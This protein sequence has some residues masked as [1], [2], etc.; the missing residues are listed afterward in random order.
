[1]AEVQVQKDLVYRANGRTWHKLDVYYPLSA[2]SKPS[3]PAVILVHGGAKASSNM[4]NT[5]P[6]VS[7]GQLFAASGISA[8]TFNWDYPEEVQIVDLIDYV[9]KNAEQLNVDQDRLCIFAFSGGVEFA[10]PTVMKSTPEY[11]RCI[12]AYYGNLKRAQAQLEEETATK[13]VPMLIVKAAQDEFIPTDSIDRFVEMARARG[14]EVHLL[15]HSKGGHAFDLRNDDDQS[16]EII[17]RTIEFVKECL[18][19]P[20]RSSQLPS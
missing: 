6:F 13:L 7:W 15:T 5:R 11:V 3:N 8:I 2:P 12:V 20:W 16:H 10:V 19:T 14:A 4:K 17:K 1:M 18:E 9:R